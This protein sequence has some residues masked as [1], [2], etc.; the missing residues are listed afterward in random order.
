MK[1]TA[2]TYLKMYRYRLLRKLIVI[3]DRFLLKHPL[4][5]LVFLGIVSCEQLTV[6]GNFE[7]VPT[8]QLRL[9]VLLLPWCQLLSCSK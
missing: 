8:K 6:Q 9:A 1:L 4:A 3:E 2:P 5:V 7:V